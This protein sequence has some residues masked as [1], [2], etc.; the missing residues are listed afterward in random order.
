MVS[1]TGRRT[2][3][4][5][6]G[7]SLLEVLVAMG[8]LVTGLA[9]VAALL[10]AAG[11]RLAEATA[12][13]RAGTL[14]ANAQADL[15][16]RRVYSSDLFRLGPME[17]APSTKRDFVTGKAV[18]FGEVL[19]NSGSLASTTANFIS[20][21]FLGLIPPNAQQEVNKTIVTTLTGSTATL[22]PAQLGVALGSR[23]GVPP[24]SVDFVSH[25]DLIYGEAT[26]SGPVNLFEGGTLLRQFRRGICYG[27]ML[28]PILFDAKVAPGSSARVSVVVFKTP[29]TKGMVMNLQPLVSKSTIFKI[30]P[31]STAIPLSPAMAEV[32]QQRFLKGCSWVLAVPPDATTAPRWFRI[33]SSWTTTTTNVLTG[34]VEPFESFVSFESE[35]ITNFKLN[36]SG[37]LM[38]IG[39]DNLLRLDEQIVF[40]E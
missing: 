26:T 27:V 36:A 35:D 8:I 24:A 14:S 25:D 3:G 32:I 4:C 34:A 2:N 30:A 5:R 33:A 17:P 7:F 40:L 22:V 38:A 29:T 11:S 10:P 13:D 18:A 15:V 21:T 20:G 16:N 9:S 37:A 31:P 12:I 19:T 6:S 1:L 23:I 39:F 28:T